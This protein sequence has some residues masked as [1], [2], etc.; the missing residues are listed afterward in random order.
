MA[1]PEIINKISFYSK[2]PDLRLR[3]RIILKSFISLIFKTEKKK[4]K[5]LSILF[6]SDAFLLKINQEFLKH[7]YYTDIITFDLSVQVSSIISEIFI[8]ID[9]VRENARVYETSYSQELHRVIFHGI[10]HLCG[11]RDQ[12]KNEKQIIRERENY[13]LDKY[14]T[15]VSREKR[16]T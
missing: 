1:K 8:S 4:I 9:R 15:Y 7:N 3:N 5:Q 16:S 10:L 2:H 11:Y 13:Y 12:L 6:V 14:K